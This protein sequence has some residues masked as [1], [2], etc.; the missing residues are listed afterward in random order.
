MPPRD[1]ANW[2]ANP[3]DLTNLLQ[4]LW[5]KRSRI[6]DGGN[7]DQTVLNE[8]AVYMASLGPP[9]KGGPKT[10]NSIDGKWKAVRKLHDFVLQVKQKTYVGASGWTYTDEGGFNVTEETQDAWKVFATAHPHFRPFATS[11][12]PHFRIVNEIVPSRARGRFVFSAAAPQPA[13]TQEEPETQPQSQPDED[14]DNSSGASQPLTDW[15][16][17]NFGDSQPPN[18]DDHP[19][20]QPPN[21]Q[22]T[23]HAVPATPAAATKRPFSDDSD[24]ATPWSNKRGRTSGPDALLFLGR[25]VQSVGM[26]IEKSFAQR[27]S[28]A[29]SP[30]K[31][32]K[33]A[34]NL[35]MEDLAAGYITPLERTR[36]SIMFGR[37]VYAA[38]A[39]AADDEGE[40]RAGV[41]R[42]LLDPTPKNSFDYMMQ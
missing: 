5:E 22:P 38:D 13:S 23:P 25:S 26:S 19:Q 41:G 18:P 14:D 37:D 34:R 8:A 33:L 42:E 16:Q 35:L 17:T 36:L 15:S 3:A 29:M 40:L 4:C 11:G 6:G 7:W 39:Y 12:W 27:E 31:K 2:T 10:A 24:S 9:E 20:S 1:A 28:S 21:S 32:I 30:T